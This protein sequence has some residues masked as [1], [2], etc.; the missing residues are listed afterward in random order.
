M[1]RQVGRVVRYRFRATFGRR[2]P[3]Y[4]A[5]V[6]LIGLIGG[7][8]MAAVAGARRTQSSFSTFLASTN[9][10][11]LTM[12][13]Y[14]FDVASSKYS[15]DLTDKIK[16]LPQVKRVES[17]IGIG[18]LPLNADGSPHIVATA[19]PVGSLDGLFFDQ[20]RATA[21]EGR[22]A[23]P[24]RDDEFET[25]ALGRGSSTCTSGRSFR[26]G[27]TRSTRRRRPASGRRP[28]PPLAVST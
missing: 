12:S 26:R 11:D 8:A 2:W 24:D 3:G 17:W 10:S 28:S 25:T 27:C 5:I 14:G 4:L 23:N 6:V 21:V 15:Q 18:A 13:T 1:T 7:V 22:L 19:S 20:D 16:R 9:P